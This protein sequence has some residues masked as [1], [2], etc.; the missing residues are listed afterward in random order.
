MLNAG[1]TLRLLT[2]Q[3]GG[4]GYAVAAVPDLPDTLARLPR[5]SH[6]AVL[7]ET[8]T[9]RRAMLETCRAIRHA[10]NLP[11]IVVTRPD[12][13]E[14]RI[15]AL[16]AGADDALSPPFC[17]AELIARLGAVSRRYVRRLTSRSDP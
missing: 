5:C 17:A 7:M 10:R 13:E 3:L 14:E 15:A 6:V 1:D 11:V 16:E 8:G 2:P 4:A 9:R 12:A